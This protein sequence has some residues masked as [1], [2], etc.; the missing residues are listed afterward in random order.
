MQ[1]I[2]W[3]MCLGYFLS[4]PSTYSLHAF[5]RRR[6][7]YTQSYS[8]TDRTPPST[9]YWQAIL[10]PTPSTTSLYAQEDS[11]DRISQDGS[12]SK[13]VVE[14]ESSFSRLEIPSPLCHLVDVNVAK[15]AVVYEVSF[16][17]D[18]GIEFC[19][20]INHPVV[21]KVSFI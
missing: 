6:M 11:W 12:G 21:S 17:K 14:G 15:R 20:G 19:Q 7:A 9:S 3:L 5:S 1:Y 18:L 4:V 16:E 10:R 8:W 13:A 2:S